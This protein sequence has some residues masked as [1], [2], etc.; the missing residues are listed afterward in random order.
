LAV[1]GYGAVL[2]GGLIWLWNGLGALA[3]PMTFYGLALASTAVLS[4]S[5]GW[6]LGL[7]GGLFLLSDLLIAVEIAEAAE[8]PGPAIWVMLTYVLAQVLLATGWVRYRQRRD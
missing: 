2:V 3:I 6:R 5:F 7:G 8:L 4:A 1:L